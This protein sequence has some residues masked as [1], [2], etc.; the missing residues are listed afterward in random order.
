MLDF[1]GINPTIWDLSNGYDDKNCS[2]VQNIR[3]RVT[4]GFKANET[5]LN[6]ASS[7]M[8]IRSRR[9]ERVINVARQLILNYVSTSCHTP[10]IL[11]GD[12]F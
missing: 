6:S 12:S 2:D 7:L 11:H 9:Q 4:N 8:N 3:A 10:L 5:F 1:V